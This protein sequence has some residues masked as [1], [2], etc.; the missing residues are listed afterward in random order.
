MATRCFCPPDSIT[1]A[2][3]QIAVIALRQRGQEV[4][5]GGGLRGCLDLSIRRV[6]PPKADVLA[7]RG[8]EDHR[9]LRH[10]CDGLAE[11]G[12]GHV[13]QGQ[14]VQRD[15]A[16]LRVIKPHQKLQDRRLACPRRA[17]Q[18]HRLARA[19]HAG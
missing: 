4:M 11:V 9:V 15:P 3:A 7:G 10:Q 5:R 13:R 1:P 17:D 18:R 14:P 19:S 12:A 16:R 8:G 6:Q 2:L